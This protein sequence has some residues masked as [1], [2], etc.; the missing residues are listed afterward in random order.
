MYMFFHV[1][2]LMKLLDFENTIQ[3]QLNM[4][5]SQ[6]EFVWQLKNGI[7][8]NQNNQSFIYASV[9]RTFDSN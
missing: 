1:F 3:L 8:K 4:S 7:W 6:Q 2:Q 9:T 5:F